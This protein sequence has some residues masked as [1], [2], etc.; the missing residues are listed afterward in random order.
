MD[1]RNTIFARIDAYVVDGLYPGLLGERTAG[2]LSENGKRNEKEG[3]GREEKTSG[4]VSAIRRPYV[5]P[6]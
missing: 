5:G 3:K 1:P 2:V 6:T 4:N